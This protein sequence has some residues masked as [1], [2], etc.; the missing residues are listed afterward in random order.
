V[1]A[2]TPLAAAP[3]ETLNLATQVSDTNAPTLVGTL[4]A[5]AIT[6]TSYTLTWPVG[7]DNIAVVGYDYSLNGGS[8]WFTLGNVLSA[9]ITGRTP[10]ATDAVK[11]R[12]RDAA[13]NV[14]T[15]V[16]ATTVTLQAATVSPSGSI[17][18]PISLTGQ[19]IIL[20]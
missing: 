3:L 19:L 1:L 8:T 20:G 2:L 11:V 15:P 12:A 10:A 17:L 6:A 9:A 4:T 5:S 16:L 7:S 13:G 14:S 18:L